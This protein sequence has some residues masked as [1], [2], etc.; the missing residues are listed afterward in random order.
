M[1]IS[2]ARRRSWPDRVSRRGSSSTPANRRFAHSCPATTACRNA[3]W[4][5]RPG[6]PGVRV[7]RPW[8]F[9]PIQDLIDFLR[10]QMLVV[11]PV[12]D[13]H[14]RAAAGSE[15][16]LLALEVDATVVR[17]LADLDAEFLLAVAQNVFA[18]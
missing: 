7:R 6:V 13:H 5:R 18:A 4:C 9:Q 2:S 10:R 3:A 8:L 11:M 12:H 15:A 16:F 17:G 1:P 14:R